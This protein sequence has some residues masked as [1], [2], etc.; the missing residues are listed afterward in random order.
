MPRKPLRLIA[1]RTLLHD[2]VV[3]AR[4]G[5]RVPLRAETLCL[6]GDRPD[7]AE[8]ARALRLALETEG[9]TVEAPG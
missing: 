6:H 1:G 2:G 7:A 8:F 9:I 4:D 3:I 5:T